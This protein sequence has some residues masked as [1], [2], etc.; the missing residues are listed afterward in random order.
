MDP[1]LDPEVV[2]SLASVGDVNNIL[3]GNNLADNGDSGGMSRWLLWTII[4]SAVA[5]VVT[6]A[7]FLVRYI[8][9]KRR[10]SNQIISDVAGAVSGEIDQKTVDVIV[11]AALKSAATSAQLEANV[12]TATQ[13]YVR[14]EATEDD[15]KKAIVAAE[16]SKADANQKNMEAT[17]ALEE[18]RK[19]ELASADAVV[20]KA[21]QDASDASAQYDK[22][23]DS[24]AAENIRKA[25][26]ALAEVQAK[27]AEADA[28]FQKATQMRLQAEKSAKDRLV[29]SAT[30]KHAAVKEAQDRLAALNS[31]IKDAKEAH[32]QYMEMQEQDE[33]LP[34]QPS[35]VP[36]PSPAPRPTPT[37][38]PAPRPT[39][40]PAPR[41]TPAPKPSCPEFQVMSN[42]QCVCDEKNG[43]V[44]D[45]KNCVCN[46]DG[47]Y[48]WNEKSRKCV[49]S[50][51]PAPSPSPPPSG[52]QITILSGEKQFQLNKGT[53]PG[54]GGKRDK[55]S[56]KVPK[57]FENAI[58]L[59]FQMYTPANM[60]AN[61]QGKVGGLFMAKRGSGTSGNASGCL[62]LKDRTGASYRA[63]FGKKDGLYQY[64][65]FQK[66]TVNDQPSGVDGLDKCGTGLF[67]NDLPV[68]KNDWNDVVMR[69][70]LND[71]GQKNG[72]SELTV[73]G[74]T[75]T[76]NNL[77]WRKDPN[78]VI[79]YVDFSSFYGGCSGGN[80]MNS[81]PSTYHKIRNMTIGP[82]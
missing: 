32:D 41:P 27:R 78:F 3:N 6:G 48:E 26:A 43:L 44:W 25:Q 79:N 73:N 53:Y 51:T 35:P 56:Y 59:R 21:V 20:L 61:C 49:K 12:Q 14:G 58:T 74:K 40:T 39:P 31:K 16:L 18:L 50:K 7:V 75:K 63:M 22:L 29:K 47:G 71:I 37:P 38:T 80:A 54:N 8:I 5:I 66:D 24:I 69:L 67:V 45:G 15:V 1:V 65:Y 55:F 17:K 60:F 10:E 52:G 23:S 2:A 11:N 57:Q 30:D 62:D 72:V 68:K 34:E 28:A 46:Y 19:Q 13:L 77:V 76:Q 81:L 9:R 33:D 4:L 64:L 82:Y 36:K 70:R 42:G